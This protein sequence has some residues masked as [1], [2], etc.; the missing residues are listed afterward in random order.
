VKPATRAED[1]DLL[2]KIFFGMVEAMNYSSKPLN[3][4]DKSV[5]LGKYL[6]LLGS[7][8]E[9]GGEKHD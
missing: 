5:L 7:L 4:P 1:F 3:P 6:P 9:D 2:Q 8:V